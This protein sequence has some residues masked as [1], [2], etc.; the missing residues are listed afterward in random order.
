MKRLFFVLSLLGSFVTL[1]GCAGLSQMTGGAPSA[2]KL[3]DGVVVKRKEYLI[4][5]LEN[6]ATLRANVRANAYAGAMT[7]LNAQDMSALSPEGQVAAFYDRTF[8]RMENMV[9]E[10]T[11][12]PDS[13]SATA[14]INAEDRKSDRIWNLVGDLS[15]GTIQALVQLYGQRE[16][17]KASERYNET[18]QKAIENAQQGNSTGVAGAS[19]IVPDICTKSSEA[20][21]AEC[22]ALTGGLGYVLPGS[23]AIPPLTPIES[24]T[25]IE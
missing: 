19:Y 23:P 6:Q 10:M 17:T 14:M 13:N 8:A 3:A 24:P 12:R 16:A 22:H 25:P 15:G 9:R 4:L 21:R 7:A 18:L 5:Q 11:A 20:S 2:V 1:T